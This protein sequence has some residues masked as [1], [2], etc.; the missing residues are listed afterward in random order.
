MPDMRATVAGAGAVIAAA[1]L[2]LATPA[3]AAGFPA[4]DC[5][6]PD[7]RGRTLFPGPDAVALT[8]AYPGAGPGA[9]A[10]RVLGERLELHGIEGLAL[11]A[12]DAPA[13]KLVIRPEDAE[14]LPALLAPGALG[15]HLAHPDAGEPGE[16]QML[17]AGRDGRE[18]VIDSEPFLTGRSVET[19][20]AGEGHAGLAVVSVTFD[21]PGARTLAEVTA[22]NVDGSAAIVVDG[23]ALMVARIM[24]PVEGG[25]LTISG[26]E[27][28]EAEALAIALATGPLPE[29]MTVTDQRPACPVEGN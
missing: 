29:G 17:V 6:G 20:E 2:A 19:A 5:P 12:S 14:A 16:G 24:T 1:L 22:A 23:A 4:Y 25:A 26:V 7:A 11:G 13:V 21:G 28:A 10:A 3:A 15:F 18:H 27:A 9:E 8:I